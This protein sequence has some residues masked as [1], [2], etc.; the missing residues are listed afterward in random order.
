MSTSASNEWDDLGAAWRAVDE[1]V[2]LGPLRRLL[3]TQRRRLVAMVAGE[4]ALVLAFGCLSWLV[5]RDG[6]APWEAVWLIT[7]WGFTAVAVAFAVW[8]RRGTWVG[9]GESVE[10]HLRLAQL[11]ARR[12]LAAVSFAI[13]LLL[14]ELVAVTAELVWYDR[15]GPVEV[16]LLAV[17]ATAAAWWCGWTR[18]RVRREL[19]LLDEITAGSR[20]T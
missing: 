5:A 17:V 4:A 2:D 3:A 6:V 8:N 7:L 9:L 11:R 19:A 20:Q 15:F 18:W 16:A 12:A 14:A 13:G 10:G 1:P